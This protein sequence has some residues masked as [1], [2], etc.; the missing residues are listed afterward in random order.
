MRVDEIE[1]ICMLCASM[2]C[3]YVCGKCRVRRLE[4]EANA[5]SFFRIT[6]TRLGIDFSW[7][8]DVNILQWLKA[9]RAHS[10]IHPAWARTYLLIF[11]YSIH[12]VLRIFNL[13][14][15]FPWDLALGG[16]DDLKTVTVN[17]INAIKHPFQ[18][19]YFEM[20]TN[21]GLSLLEQEKKVRL[22]SGGWDQIYMGKHEAIDMEKLARVGIPKSAG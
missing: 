3:V 18:Y 7:S 19:S 12:M 21:F 17:T 1:C 9:V 22:F 15:T 4:D 8:S 16:W 20:F 11:A 10:I 6:A 5:N 14:D 13:F 2:V